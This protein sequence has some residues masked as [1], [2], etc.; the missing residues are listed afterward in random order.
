[1]STLAQFDHKWLLQDSLVVAPMLLGAVLISHAGNATAGG[2][3][4]EVEAYRGRKDP[5]SQAYGPQSA[6][7]TPMYDSGGAIY[8]YRSYGIHACMN[9]V[10]GRLGE[11]QAVLIR[12]L[13][14]TIGISQMQL[15]R[16]TSDSTKLTSGPGRLCQALGITLSLTGT[17]L[18]NTILLVSPD[19]PM[20]PARIAT[21]PRIGI[22][23]A[24]APEWRF[25]IRDNKF[26]S[27]RK[28]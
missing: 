12:A 17:R 23:K 16:R 20:E 19:R 4:V 3:I 14:P 15:S 26:V 22:T 9:I 25:Y 10:T 11:P 28:T 5:A 8:V 1:M 18:G 24:T 6:R 13:E 2:I 7:N 21:S 27:G